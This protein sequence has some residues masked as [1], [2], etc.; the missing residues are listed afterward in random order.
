MSGEDF[1][2][3]LREATLSLDPPNRA[4]LF[5]AYKRLSTFIS[6]ARPESETTLTPAN[7]PHLHTSSL[8]GDTIC[9]VSHEHCACGADYSKCCVLQP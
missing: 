9:D 3:A 7:C 5:E 8:S 2:V 4:I 1:L 6:A